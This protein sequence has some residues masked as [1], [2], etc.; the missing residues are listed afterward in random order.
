MREMTIEATTTT[1]R[2]RAS[3][4]Y[5]KDAYSS[6]PIHAPLSSLD[7]CLHSPQTCWLGYSTVPLKRWL[8]SDPFF[9]LNLTESLPL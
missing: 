7:D 5:N 1:A 8:W 6:F 3:L 2:R 4:T 9:S